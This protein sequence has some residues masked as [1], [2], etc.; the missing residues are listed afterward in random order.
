[1]I[2]F[3]WS[4]NDLVAAS[5]G[6]GM[7]LSGEEWL[8]PGGAAIVAVSVREDERMLEILEAE[9]SDFLKRSGAPMPIFSA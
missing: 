4:D 7:T 1:M 3:F 5:E 2:R 8:P 9:A 6:K